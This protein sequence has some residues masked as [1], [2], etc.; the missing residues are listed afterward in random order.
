MKKQFLLMALVMTPL[1]KSM[2]KPVP[3]YATPIKILEIEK[4][5]KTTVPVVISKAFRESPV[6]GWD[7]KID[8]SLTAYIYSSL[9]I[10]DK[11]DAKILEPLSPHIIH[12]LFIMAQGQVFQLNNKSIGPEDADRLIELSQRKKKKKVLSTITLKKNE[13]LVITIDKKGNIKLTSRS[14]E[15]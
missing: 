10:K 1:A 14:I 5:I 9:D 15:N 4:Y 8:K 11:E 2:D 6:T 13:G 3:A 12:T 7:N